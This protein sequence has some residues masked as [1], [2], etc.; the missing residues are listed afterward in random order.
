MPV[1]DHFVA[2]GVHVHARLA[3]K[4][5][6]DQGCEE[7]HVAGQRKE[8]KEPDPLQAFAWAFFGIL[9]IIVSAAAPS[10]RRPTIKGG[11]TANS[12]FFP[13]N[14]RWG[15]GEGDGHREASVCVR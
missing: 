5:Q 2:A 10:A 1:A 8:N 3:R 12:G 11:L 4:E 15:A 6:H 14:F 9:P 7:H 13:F